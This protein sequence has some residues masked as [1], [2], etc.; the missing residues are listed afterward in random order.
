MVTRRYTRTILLTAAFYVFSAAT[1]GYFTWHAQNGDRGLKAK[2][3]YKLKIAELNQEFEALRRE[4][5][6]WERRVQQMRAESLDRD[7]L[8]EQSRRLLNSAH[9]NDVIVILGPGN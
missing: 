8:D 7:L 2:S 9:R 3:S 6:D 1:V 4:R 5:T